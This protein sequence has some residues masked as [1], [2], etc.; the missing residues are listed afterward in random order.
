[1]RTEPPQREARCARAG[2]AIQRLGWSESRL[3][4]ALRRSQCVHARARQQARRGP[5][6]RTRGCGV[7][8]Q[9]CERHAT[10][11]A[12]AA[13]AAAA[14]LHVKV[15]W[16]RSLSPTNYLGANYKNK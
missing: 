14:R 8:V 12:A 13:A 16:P 5:P 6:Q 11:A 1:V 7:H 4:A 9:H 10:C 15:G 2:E 3:Q